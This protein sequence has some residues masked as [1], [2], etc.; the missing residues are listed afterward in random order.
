MF[1]LTYVYISSSSDAFYS[2]VKRTVFKTALW[3]FLVKEL[4][5]QDEAKEIGDRYEITSDV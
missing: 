2:E 1:V 4:L 5:G 3:N